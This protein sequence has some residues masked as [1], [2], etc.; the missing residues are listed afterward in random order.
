MTYMKKEISFEVK[1]YE[2]PELQKKY[3]KAVKEGLFDKLK[4]AREEL[5]KKGIR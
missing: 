1:R 5:R 4:K 2:D 3:E